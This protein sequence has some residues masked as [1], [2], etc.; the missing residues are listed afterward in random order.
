M[1]YNLGCVYW[2]GGQ[3]KEAAKAFLSAI[4]INPDDPAIHYNLGILYDDDLKMPEKALKH[5]KR[6]LELSPEDK[7]AGKVYEW[8]TALE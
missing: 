6:F 2:H 4:E 7:D 1:Q 5:Y 8:M 3:N